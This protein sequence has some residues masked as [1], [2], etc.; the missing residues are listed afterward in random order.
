MLTRI[1]DIFPLNDKK[2]IIG[3]LTSS[4]TAT[5]ILS[6]NTKRLE[7]RGRN[8]R[9]YGEFGKKQIEIMS[10][11]VVKPLIRMLGFSKFSEIME[12]R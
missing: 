6:L 11:N 3:S 2:A 7:K 12:Q 5:S 1:F 10:L 4:S 9:D 8:L